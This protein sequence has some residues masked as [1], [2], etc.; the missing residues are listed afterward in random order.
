MSNKTEKLYYENAYIS[1]FYASVISTQSIDGGYDVILDKT[2]FFPEEGGQSA[3]TGYIAESRV[4]NVYEKDGVI[5]HITDTEPT[6]GEHWCSVD[7]DSRFEKMQCHTAEHILCGIIH[8]LFGF[9]NVGFHLGDDEVTFDVSGVLDRDQL[10]RVEE[11][12][13][14]VVFSNIQVEAFFPPERRLPYIKY[15]S[16]LDIAE[17]VRLVRIGEVD[18]CACCAPHVSSTGEIGI[19]KILDFM[20]HRGGTRIWMTAGKRALI[21]YR[22]RYENIKKISGMLS[23][24]QSDV[25]VTLEGYISDCEEMK[26]ALKSARLKIAELYAMTVEPTE[27]N[28]VILLPDL[29][30]PELIAF[31]N[32]ANKRVGKITVALSGSDGDYKY[33]ISSSSVDLSTLS[34]DIN[35][36][37][38]GRGGGRA[39]MLQGSFATALDEI[40]SYFK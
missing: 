3:D 14:E 9:D 10:D 40:K 25:A 11:M 32:I 28:L 27:G 5:H 39:E 13:N 38:C 4:L 35:A 33:V 18:I 8:S 36:A 16:K 15:R 20:K 26:A 22:R 30:I 23:A 17:G 31:S 21:D 1:D 24:P 2:A 37:L 7:F 12:A 6:L 19:I 29:T 34:K